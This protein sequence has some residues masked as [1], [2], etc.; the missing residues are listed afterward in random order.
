M[1]PLQHGTWRFHLLSSA[2]PLPG[3]KKQTHSAIWVFA[4]MM[5]FWNGS[6][7]GQNVLAT[8][9]GTDWVFPSNGK[10]PLSAP[11]SNIQNVTLDSNG[12][13][14]FADPGNAVVVRIEAS[15]TVTVLAGNGL[16]RYSGDGGL[17]VNAALN[18]PTDATFDAN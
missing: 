1:A 6:A 13:I 2:V 18:T 11:F 8:Y 7:L 5:S 16:Q 9:S 12:R 17:A 3:R 10:P 15:G 4:L 14:V